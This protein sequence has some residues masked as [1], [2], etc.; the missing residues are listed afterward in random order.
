M[1]KLL[2]LYILHVVLLL[3]CSKENDLT[4]P[5]PVQQPTPTVPDIP[6]N[7]DAKLLDKMVATIGNSRIVTFFTYDNKGRILKEETVDSVSLFYT[8]SSR[9]FMRDT[10]GRVIRISDEK[11][12][13]GSVF[14]TEFTDFYYTSSSNR[15]LSHS[16]RYAES[17]GLLKKDTSFYLNNNLGLVEARNL[18]RG[19]GPDVEQTFRY[20]FDDRKN[21]A[22]IDLIRIELTG[23]FTGERVGGGSM[24]IACDNKVNPLYSPEDAILAY[25]ETK[26]YA[27][28]NNPLMI[29]GLGNAVTYSYEYRADGRPRKVTIVSGGSKRQYV[30]YYRQ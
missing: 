4:D 18:I 10:I 14:S 17:F 30:Y 11:F 22:G 15:A 26:H 7:L 16:I 24:T 19:I 5:S 23:P 28:A 8:T 3:S 9:I 2:V 6:D 27:S 20:A 29:N 25:Y 1:K 12:V 13:S 21:L